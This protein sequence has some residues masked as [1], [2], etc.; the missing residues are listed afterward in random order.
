V[1]GCA[2]VLHWARRIPVGWWYATVISRHQ[3]SKSARQLTARSRGESV[4]DWSETGMQ[5]CVE[6]DFRNGNKHAAQN[7]KHHDDKRPARGPRLSYKLHRLSIPW[8]GTIVACPFAQILSSL[9]METSTG[10]EQGGNKL[11]LDRAHRFRNAIFKASL[12]AFKTLTLNIGRGWQPFCQHT[13][14]PKKACSLARTSHAWH[15]VAPSHHVTMQD[16]R[17]GG[18]SQAISYRN[19]LRAKR[20]RKKAGRMNERKEGRKEGNREEKQS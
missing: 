5:S 16:D 18:C 8:T 19:T 1:R 17:A 3:L 2:E 14:Q 11:S 12:R 13:R 10:P 4:V 20:Q 7:H 6:L 15:A 9:A